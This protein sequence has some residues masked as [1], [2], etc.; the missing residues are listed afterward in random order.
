[1]ASR[2][3]LLL[4]LTIFVITA[5]IVTLPAFSGNFLKLT[6]D[7]GIHLSRL[8]S[9]FGAFSVGKLPPL[10]NFIG[11]DNHVNAF[12]GM[13]PW[14]STALFFTLPRLILGSPMQSMFIGYILLNLVTML[15]AYLLVKELSSDNIVRIFSAIF[16][17]VNAYHLTLLFSREALGEAVAYTFAPLVILG[18]LRI[19]NRRNKGPIYLAIGM[20]MIANSHVISLF[21][22]FL[23]LII[24]EVVRII[25]KKVDLVEIKSFFIG[26]LIT[27]LIGS[28]SLF[29]I[30]KITIA[31]NMH[32]PNKGLAPIIPS[33]M[34]VAVFDNSIQDDRHIFNIGLIGLVLILFLCVEL[35]KKSKVGDWT[36]WA[37]LAVILFICSTSWLQLEKTRATD[38]VF[39]NIQFLG[40]I[41]ALIV[42]LMTVAVTIYVEE[43][44]SYNK[45]MLI[46]TSILLVLMG[47]SSISQYHLRKNDDPIRYYVSNSHG[48]SKIAYTQP[49]GKGDYAL[50]EVKNGGMLTAKANTRIENYKSTF[51]SANFNVNA[52]NGITTVPINMY[53]NVDYH[54]YVD[55][56][57][58]K[59]QSNKKIL[60]INLKKGNHKIKLVSK[61]GY[62][63]Y[64]SMF[65]SCVS[66]IGCGLFIILVE[67]RKY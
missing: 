10:V 40:R 9:V 59:F 5:V 6:M 33:K 12:N 36:P 29:N 38:S 67:P 46:G 27:I 16:Y 47:I 11:L 66:L 48:F 25:L 57:K 34:L 4:T 53:K 52:R 18:C 49:H 64:I 17:G 31:N 22:I 13:Y 58:K 65:I 3:P 14:F 45:Y 44:K 56:K 20:G 61:A 60:T 43:Q 30:M 35:F 19:W 32:T 8:E 1:M 24:L 26:G 41:L 55:G 62:S 42:L 50:V 39:G 37:S 54:L 21:L 51:D 28:Y 7:G 63:E 15:N 2:R 23:L